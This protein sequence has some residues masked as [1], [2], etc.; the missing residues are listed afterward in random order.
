[1]EIEGATKVK[2]HH[3]EAFRYILKIWIKFKIRNACV[4]FCKLLRSF[5]RG[6]RNMKAYSLAK[7][8]L[9][10]VEGRITLRFTI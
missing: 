4:T 8:N 2:S 5:K 7:F 6:G 9:L 10:I 3:D 1:M